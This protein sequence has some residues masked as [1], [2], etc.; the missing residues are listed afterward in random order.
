MAAIGNNRGSY[1]TMIDLIPD[2]VLNTLSS[3]QIADLVDATWLACQQAKSIACADAIAEGAIWDSR[4][5][6]LREVA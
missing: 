1:A 6:R 4:R 5:Q 2:T 3:R